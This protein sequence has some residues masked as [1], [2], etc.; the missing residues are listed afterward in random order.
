MVHPNFEALVSYVEGQL[1]ESDRAE[2]EQHLSSSCQ[3][4]N[5]KVNRLR[6]VLKA[7]KAD[8]T[9]APPAAVLRKAIAIRKK[10]SAPAR[11]PRLRVLAQLLFDSRIQLSPMALRGVAHTRQMLFTTQ[12]MDIDLQITPERGENNLVGQILGSDQTNDPSLA[13]VSLKKENGEVIKGA[14]TDSLG[15]FTI[16]QIPP[17]VYDLVFDLDSQEVAITSLEFS[18]DQ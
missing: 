17:G 12:Q 10:R 7:A 18:N 13:F 3:T 1:P 2:M 14:E 16:R 5:E 8:Q 6:A 9:I 4:C 15:Q 11:E